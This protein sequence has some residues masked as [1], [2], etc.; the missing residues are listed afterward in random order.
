MGIGVKSQTDEMR[1][2]KIIDHIQKEGGVAIYAHPNRWPL[3][4]G[5]TLRELLSVPGVCGIE[6]INAKRWRTNSENKM[7]RFA[8]PRVSNLGMAGDDC[9]S[10]AREANRA[11]VVVAAPDLRED[12]II[13]AFAKRPLLFY[14]RAGPLS[15]SLS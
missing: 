2:D 10:I 13:A 3:F 6:V 1:P 4:S 15:K 9:H 14:R 7:G 12:S 11:W 8:D 5:W